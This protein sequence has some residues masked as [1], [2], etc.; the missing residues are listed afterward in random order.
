M[1]DLGCGTATLTLLLKR[2]HPEATVAGIDGD[3]NILEIA[4]RKAN[5]YGL[6]II[7]A[8]GMAFNLPY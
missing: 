6:D 1:L 2:T 3:A 8:Q 4:R 5:E 7:F